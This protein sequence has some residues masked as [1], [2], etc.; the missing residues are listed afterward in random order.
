MPEVDNSNNGF[1]E[2]YIYHNITLQ[3]KYNIVD[4]QLRVPREDEYAT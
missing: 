2:V 1:P 3:M 4:Q